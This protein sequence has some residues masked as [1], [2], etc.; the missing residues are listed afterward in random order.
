MERRKDFGYWREDCKIFLANCFAGENYYLERP[1]RIR[2]EK[3]ICA[4]EHGCRPRRCCESPCIFLE[5][6]RRDSHVSQEIWIQQKIQFYLNG[7]WSDAGIF[8]R[9]AAS[10]N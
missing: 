8:R 2:G 10:R 7:R 9:E 1:A 3:T 5:R 4:R 6:R